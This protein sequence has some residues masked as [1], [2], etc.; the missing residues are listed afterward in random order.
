MG[1][2]ITSIPEVETVQ[3]SVFAIAEV[4]LSSLVGSP[5]SASMPTLKVSDV[6]SA[7]VDLGVTFPA[8]GTGHT[9]EMLGFEG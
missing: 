7:A 3:F 5:C 9:A 2:V 1:C 4:Q 6:L 8:P